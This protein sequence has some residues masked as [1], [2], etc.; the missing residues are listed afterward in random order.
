MKPINAEISIHAL[1]EEGDIGQGSVCSG[2]DISIHALREEGDSTSASHEGSGVNFYPRPPRGGR[3]VG[4]ADD[5]VHLDFYPRPPRGGRHW[6][7][8]RPA[9]L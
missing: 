3:P 2:Q 6:L 1:R 8:I 9:G 4:I 5:T 7:A